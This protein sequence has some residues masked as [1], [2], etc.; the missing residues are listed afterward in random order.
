MGLG[1]GLGLGSRLGIG[2]GLEL[3]RLDNSQTIASSNNN[4]LLKYNGTRFTVILEYCCIIS[5]LFS[6]NAM[7][8][9]FVDIDGIVDHHCLNFLNIIL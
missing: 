6:H 9:H 3:G 5:N 8:V 2:L 1:L 4:L 7:I